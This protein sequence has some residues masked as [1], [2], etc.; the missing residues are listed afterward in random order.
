MARKP[1]EFKFD[2]LRSAIQ[3]AL[4]VAYDSIFKPA[5]QVGFVV[6][7]EVAQPLVAASQHCDE[8]VFGLAPIVGQVA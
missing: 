4:E 2:R 7:A 5:F 3:S 8:E 1:C 6:G